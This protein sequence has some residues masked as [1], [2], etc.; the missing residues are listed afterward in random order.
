M[1]R[2]TIDTH[3]VPETSY[4]CNSDFLA[5]SGFSSFSL[6]MCLTAA[7]IAATLITYFYLVALLGTSP[8]LSVPIFFAIVNH[9][10]IYNSRVLLH[11]PRA[12]A[13]WARASKKDEDGEETR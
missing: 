7:K 4:M 2:Y 12:E 6:M 13:N 3:R 10:P 9:L 8:L 1:Y 11:I 5:A